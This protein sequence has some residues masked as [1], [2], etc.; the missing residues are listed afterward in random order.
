MFACVLTISKHLQDISMSIPLIESNL[1]VSASNLLNGVEE[2]WNLLC[3]VED[4]LICFHQC[5]EIGLQR[6]N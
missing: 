6:V 5:F 3:T 1:L 4:I 2:I